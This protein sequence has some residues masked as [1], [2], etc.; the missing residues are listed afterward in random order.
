MRSQRTVL[1]E[2]A[3]ESD[4]GL[5]REA[6]ERHA[7]RRSLEECLGVCRAASNR[8]DGQRQGRGRWFGEYGVMSTKA[9]TDGQIL[10]RGRCREPAVFTGLATNLEARKRAC[11]CQVG[12]GR[13][14]NNEA[15]F[16]RSQGPKVAVPSRSS[17]GGGFRVSVPRHPSI[18]PGQPGQ[19]GQPRLDTM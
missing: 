5:I 13:K 19:P 11:R 14:G 1:F 2:P 10:C 8:E 12:L 4:R 9:T 6:R 16:P 18:E 7:S 3:C 15:S 17:P